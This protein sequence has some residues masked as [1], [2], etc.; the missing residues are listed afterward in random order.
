MDRAVP[1]RHGQVR[2]SIAIEIRHCAV[3]T[4][5]VDTDAGLRGWNASEA[6]F[7]I[8]EEKETQASLH[9]PAKRR[10]SGFILGEHQIEISIVVKVSRH[11][12]E[13]G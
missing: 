1:F 7:A 4:V 12:S 3:P 5:A 8:A 6:A 13:R 11:H 9:G 10:H 2:P